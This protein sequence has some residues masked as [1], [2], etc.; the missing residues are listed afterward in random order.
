MTTISVRVI[1]NCD[2]VYLIWQPE[3]AIADC[4]GFAIYRK[5][6]GAA[7][8]L[9]PN[10]VGFSAQ[11]QQDYQPQPSSVWPF[12]RISW[13]DHG[14]EIGDTL[15]YRI[16]AMVGKPDAL[17]EGVASDWTAPVKL[18]AECGD[19]ISAHFNRGIVLSQFVARLMKKN[20]WKVAD[21]KTHAALA[22]DQL[23]EFLSG[24]LRVAMLDMLQQAQQDH[25]VE[26]Y[27]ALFELS[28]PE[29]GAELAKLGPRLHCVLGNGA[30][31]AKTDDE[32]LAMRTQLRAAGADIIDRMTAPGFLAHNKF[33]VFCRNGQPYQAWTGSTNWQPTGLC[34]QVNNGIMLENADVAADYFA[35]WQRLKAA[36]NLSDATLKQGNS[37]LPVVH[38]I[39][40]GNPGANAFARFTATNKKID[41]TELSQLIAYAKK[42]IF[43]L[44]FMPGNDL[45]QQVIAKGQS[46]YVRG[47]ANTIPKGSPGTVQVGL[48]D[49]AAQTNFSLEVI[50]PTG[51]ANAFAYWAEEVTRGQFGAIGHAIIHS[52]TIV[53]DAGT[54]DALVITG[55]HNFSNTASQKNDENYVV[56]HGNQA[57]ADAYVANCQAV[58]DHYRWRKYV[59]D[60]AKQGKQPWDHLA[61]DA[62]WLAKY[63]QSPSRKATLD[64]W[65]GDNGK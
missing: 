41:L 11:P 48:V 60:C 64:F 61:D 25:S 34:T 50:E 26:V 15:S 54:P 2:D 45:F 22:H 10:R 63:V 57:L 53:L 28:D 6:N 18:T 20:N 8:E 38:A 35:A 40:K 23:R 3:A 4:L 1:S 58:Y 17:T 9:L 19:G 24:D 13:T 33:A 14:S 49:G 44:M 59:A 56:V 21:I 31:K 52:K 47:V 65:F 46:L 37:V 29:L 36:G 55:S 39:D 12:Q 62:D 16:V 5:R 51:V 7:P 43:F 42:S 30:V 32:N 27:A